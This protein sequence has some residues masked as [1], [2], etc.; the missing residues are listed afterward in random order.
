MIDFKVY[1]RAAVIQNVI[2]D[3]NDARIR[4][5]VHYEDLEWQSQLTSMINFLR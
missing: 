4:N 5:S 3:F 2:V 1:V